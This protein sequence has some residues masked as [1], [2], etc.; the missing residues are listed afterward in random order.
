MI[1]KIYRAQAPI[2]TT[3][4]QVAQIVDRVNATM[5]TK[6]EFAEHHNRL[7]LSLKPCPHAPQSAP[8]M[9]QDTLASS[10]V[11]SYA[12]YYLPL[13]RISLWYGWRFRE[14]DQHGAD[15][16]S[17]LTGHWDFDPAP[18][19]SYRGIGIREAACTVW[20]TFQTKDNTKF[21]CQYV[22]V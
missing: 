20:G 13:G 14:P 16:E 10:V 8:S 6:Q 15:E 9:A 21:D 22:C 19:V 1:G 5:V 4:T 12:N 18:W 11:L 7:R 17:L 3:V 2:I